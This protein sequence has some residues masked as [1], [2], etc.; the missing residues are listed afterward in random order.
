MNTPQENAEQPMPAASV[1]KNDEGMICV[2]VLNIDSKLMSSTL[3]F[4]IFE[5]AQDA[6]D[7]L[8]NRGL[9]AEWRVTP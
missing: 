6:A 8:W 7:W 3:Q 5:R 9:S 1:H 2:S 4:R